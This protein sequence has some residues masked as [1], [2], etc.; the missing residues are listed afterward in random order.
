MP[1][2]PSLE[3]AIAAPFIQVSFYNLCP[4]EENQNMNPGLM[5]VHM[6]IL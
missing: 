1:L 6:S 2:P 4:P 3:K 5:I